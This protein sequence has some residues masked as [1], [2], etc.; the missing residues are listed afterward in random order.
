MKTRTKIVGGAACRPRRHQPGHERPADADPTL[1]A[2]TSA[3]A[4]KA[5]APSSKAPA[6]EETTP[7]PPAPS[8]EAP[9]EPE[10]TSGQ[11]N[12]LR[13]A[14]G[15]LSMMGM[16]KAGLIR[17]LSSSAG[18]GYSKS[19]ATSRRTTSKPTGT[20]RRSSPPRATCR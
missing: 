15:Y 13:S 10:M 5:P 18:E 12:A 20:P 9:T 19:D 8:S 3:P 14:E 16:S 7:E 17:Q 11:A 4:P 2:S 6:P 1:A